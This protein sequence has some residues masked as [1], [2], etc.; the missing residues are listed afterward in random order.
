MARIIREDQPEVTSTYEWLYV[1]FTGITIG[2]LYVG[3]MALIQQYVIEPLYC[4]SVVDATVCTNSQTI[5]GNISSILVAIAALGLFI[6]LRV[7]RPIIIVVAAAILL[8]GLSSWTAGLGGFEIVASSAILYGLAYLMVS[9]ICRYERTIPV[10][11]AM[12][13]IVLGSR[14]I[15]LS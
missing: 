13:F 8:W 10:V 2:I 1:L 3:L 12:V 5:S 15:G 4:K 7:F 11:V 9:W 6:R 14:L